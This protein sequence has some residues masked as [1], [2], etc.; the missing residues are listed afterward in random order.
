VHYSIKREEIKTEIEILGHTLTNFW[1][2]KQYSAK[3]TNWKPRFT[4]SRGLEVLKKMERNNLKHISTRDLTYWPLDKNKLLD[5]VDFC[6]TSR[7]PHCS[8][9]MFRPIL[10]TFAGLDHTN[11]TCAEPREATKLSCLHTTWDV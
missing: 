4:T 11:N 5:L 2:I 1:N 8:K 9:I 3:N 7:R 6:V 10:Q